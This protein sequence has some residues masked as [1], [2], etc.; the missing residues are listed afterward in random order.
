M[1]QGNRGENNTLSC[2]HRGMTGQPAIINYLDLCPNIDCS[3]HYCT[4]LTVQVASTTAVLCIHSLELC[5]RADWGELETI[6]DY[7]LFSLVHHWISPPQQWVM[8]GLG[9]T[10]SVQLGPTQ[11]RM[12]TVS[13]SASSQRLFHPGHM[14]TTTCYRFLP[15][16]SLGTSDTSSLILQKIISKP[17]RRVQSMHQDA[18]NQEK[19][20]VSGGA[21]AGVFLPVT[22]SSPSLAVSGQ[23][24]R[25]YVRASL[26]GWNRFS[27]RVLRGAEKNRLG[28][29]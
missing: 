24:N 15:T 7:G 20:R 6:L 13:Y 29:P 2:V 22:C 18:S 11:E 28:S 8:Y 16:S 25:V 10:G 27:G 5:R 14:A 19:T 21:A 17:A 9:F 12:H 23:C 4:T 26:F 1:S 3:P